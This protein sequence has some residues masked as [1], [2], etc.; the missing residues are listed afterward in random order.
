MYDQGSGA[1]GQVGVTGPGCL[2]NP[3]DFLLLKH[4]WW[5]GVTYSDNPQ[6]E[7]V[8]SRKLIEN[9]VGY[10]TLSKPPALTC[11]PGTSLE[12]RLR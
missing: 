6:L 10:C 2:S 3:D 1:F 8:G 11:R 7:T 5:S 12:T 9:G 4:P